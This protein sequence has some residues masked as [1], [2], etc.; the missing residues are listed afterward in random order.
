MNKTKWLLN[1]GSAV[2]L[3]IKTWKIFRK[4][5]PNYFASPRH[6]S[7]W[8]IDANVATAF[9]VFQA[10]NCTVKN[11]YVFFFSP[12]PTPPLPWKF[13]LTHSSHFLFCKDVT[14]PCTWGLFCHRRT[15]RHY[16]PVNGTVS[17]HP[18]KS[19]KVFSSHFA[20]A[21]SHLTTSCTP[22]KNTTKQMKKNKS[23][24]FLPLLLSTC[25][26]SMFGMASMRKLTFLSSTAVNK[27]PK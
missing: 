8:I 18:R 6:F 16:K 2:F 11:E 20:L 23:F 19:I 7:V 21:V 13:V 27:T 25:Q 15:K 10:R 5:T 4:K 26:D 14:L 24:V 12:P 3:W 1:S 17:S 22:P 9:L